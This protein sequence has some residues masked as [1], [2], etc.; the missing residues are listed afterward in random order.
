MLACGA[1][2][3]FNG[4]PDDDGLPDVDDPENVEIARELEEAD[5]VKL[6]DGYFYLAN[7]YTGLRIIDARSMTQPIM[8]GRVPLGGRAVEL[9]V[10]NGL[11]YVFTS[12]DLHRCAGQAVGFDED[13][14]ITVNPDFDGSRLWVIDV[15]DPD[16]PTLVSQ[17]DLD[18]LIT[19]TRRVGD[20]IYAAGQ[21]VTENWSGPTHVF[22]TSVNIADPENI[23]EVET[24]TFF[25]TSLDI[26]ASTTAMYILGDDPDLD[27]STLVTYVDISDPDGN[28]A[29]R[30][31]FRVPGRIDNRFFVDEQDTAFRIITTEYIWETYEYSTALY[32]YNIM[33]PDDIVRAGKLQ[34]VTDRGLKSVR[35]DGDR[36]YA[37]TTVGYNPL[38]VLDLSDAA[39]PRVAGEAETPGFSTHLVPIGDRLVGVGFDTSNGTRPAVVLYNVS[40]PD[41]PTMLSW[42]I[43]GEAGRFDTSSEAF[44]DEK[45][46]RVVEDANLILMP[47]STF[48]EESGEYVDALQMIGMES[49]Q[50]KERGSIEHR[51][52]I[53]RADVESS[54]L[55]ILSDLAFQS[56]NISS[57]DNPASLANL[58]LISD[59]DI[60]DGGLSGCVDSARWRGTQVGGYYYY[61]TF[62]PCSLLGLLTILFATKVLLVDRF[63]SKAK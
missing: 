21:I 51:G 19:A 52:L 2:P 33:N 32:T 39:N 28:I 59:Q 17:I 43:V 24:E 35:F 30:D 44:V 22:V 1:D 8:K 46:I 47:Y 45:A 13:M 26:Y 15:S 6:E 5:I 4:G 41:H 58:H 55:W 18:G 12:A 25:G 60:L 14:Q 54:R 37:V 11:A 48:D 10:R 53:R 31:Q 63:L 29:A 36:A 23:F 27:E 38:Y 3:S 40:D 56:N 16:S 42:I 34:I 61:P 20:V 7:A 50:L 9:F 62:D 49:W 57:L